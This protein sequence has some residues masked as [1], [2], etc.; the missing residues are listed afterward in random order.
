MSTPK[1]YARA[2]VSG[3]SHNRAKLSADYCGRV[4]AWIGRVAPE[5]TKDKTALAAWI[6]D[7]CGQRNIQI[8]D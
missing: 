1:D 7:E 6:V 2:I 3:I 8:T 4:L 5:V